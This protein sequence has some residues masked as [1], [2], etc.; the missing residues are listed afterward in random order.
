MT[1]VTTYKITNRRHPHYNESGID[2]GERIKSTGQIILELTNCT[3]GTK[4]CAIRKG[5]V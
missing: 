4:R 5:D 2:T 1:I 3:H